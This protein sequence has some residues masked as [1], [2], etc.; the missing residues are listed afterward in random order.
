MSTPPKSVIA[1]VT[2]WCNVLGSSKSN[3]RIF[4]FEG[5]AQDCFT[6]SK[7]AVFLEDKIKMAFCFDNS[8]ANALPMP[9]EAPVI[10]TTLLE[11][12]IFLFLS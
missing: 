8:I 9:E 7:A 3:A 12:P 10:Q 4:T 2:F 6:N 11:K 5:S 1:A